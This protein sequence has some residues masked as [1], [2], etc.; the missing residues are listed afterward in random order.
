[1][2]I[3][4]CR[5]ATVETPFEVELDTKHF[6]LKFDT[7]ES[8]DPRTMGRLLDPVMPPPPSLQGHEPELKIGS[9]M[10]LFRPKKQEGGEK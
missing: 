10:D 7:R 5:D 8:E 1:M 2:Q 9:V 6:S 3:V 4:K